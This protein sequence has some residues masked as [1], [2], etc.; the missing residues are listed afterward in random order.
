MIEAI[1]PLAV[2]IV[3]AGGMGRRHAH[4]LH[5]K[6]KGAMVAGVYDLDAGRTAQVAA[7]CGAAVFA[8]PYELIA[9]ERIDAVLIAS[10]DDTHADFVLAC[11]R[12]HKPVLCE[13]PLAANPADGRRIVETEA[14]GGRKMVT[15]G[16]MRRFDPY[17]V[18]V[19]EAVASGS[20]GQ[21]VLFRGIHRNAQ[22]APDLPRH[23]IVTGSAVH[24]VDSARWLLQQEVEEVFAHGRRIDPA[25]A[26]DAIDLLLLQLSMSG[27]CL[28]TIEV[29]ISARYGYEVVAEI[30]GERGAAVT[31]APN[32]AI[33]LRQRRRAAAI[34]GE[35]LERFQDA[36]VI[37]LEQWLQSLRGRP[38]TG[39]SAWD[40]YVALVV[41]E[42]CI[43]S[44]H[45]GQPQS[46][47]IAA[48]PGLYSE[49]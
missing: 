10:P 41:A 36:Y 13:K 12:Q 38:F 26:D 48:R 19:K 25:V 23:L 1:P 7:E 9:D 39:A 15:V 21:P 31:A 11:L 3:G 22:A 5:H 30:A 37:E 33:L 40:G 29:Y 2:G 6:V 24:D 42:A 8:N 17:H 45:S 35:W 14:A 16:F 28:A 47:R 43:A 27:N 20:L 32:L 46:V 49:E 44:L 34:H 18:A 4:N